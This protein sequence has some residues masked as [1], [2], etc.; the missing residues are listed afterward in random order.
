[1]SHFFS[2]PNLWVRRFG[3]FPDIMNLFVYLLP[4]PHFQVTHWDCWLSTGPIFKNRIRQSFR[5]LVLAEYDC[6]WSKDKE[7]LGGICYYSLVFTL[8]ISGVS[9]CHCFLFKMYPPFTSTPEPFQKT[10]LLDSYWRSPWHSSLG[11]SSSFEYVLL[12][13]QNSLWK[14]KQNMIMLKNFQWFPFG[15]AGNI[16]PA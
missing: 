14:T 4:F 3:L 2:Y 11:F 7:T 5:Y 9:K 15:L 13:I 6:S 8:S 10:F 1:M 12:S 16:M